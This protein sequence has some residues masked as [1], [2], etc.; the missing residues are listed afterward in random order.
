MN[1]VRIRGSPA[2]RMETGGATSRVRP[3]RAVA[4]L[5][6][7]N[8]AGRP[9]DNWLSTA[10]TEMLSTELAAGGGLRLVPGRRRGPRQTRTAA[11]RRRHSGQ[12]PPWTGCGQTR[13]RML[14]SWAPTPCCRAR[15]RIASGWTFELQDTAGGETIAEEALTGSEDKLFEL[16]AQAGAELRQS[17]GVNSVS[18]EAISA[19]RAALPS[20]QEA[21]RLYAEGRAKLWAFDFQ[22]ARDLLVKA[23]AADPN[24]PLAHSALSEAWWHTGYESKARAEA[25]QALDL[26]QHLPQEEQLLVEGQYRRAIADW[27]KTVQAYQTLFH[28]FPDRLDYGLLLASAQ[29]YIRPAESL[30]TLA[31]LRHL[32]PPRR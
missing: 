19:A 12:A 31:T 32:P 29:M 18:A 15:M 23:V 1:S 24:Y 5:G 20:N 9:D 6:F 30:Q 21:V 28:L 25:Q 8:L 16:A 13:G 14:W 11:G 17:L 22:G 4:V 2:A 7:R 27:P 26:S 3:R 10:F